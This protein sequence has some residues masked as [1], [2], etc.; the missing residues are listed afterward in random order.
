MRSF[1]RSLDRRGGRCL[2]I[3][4][5]ACVLYGAALFTEDVDLWLRP[6]ARDLRALLESLASAGAR[7]HKLTPP[8]TLSMLKRG[9]GFHFLI[10][11]DTYLDV[12]GRPPRVGTFASA[13]SRARRIETD[14]GRLRVVCP[15]DLVLLK[16]TNR[17]A[18]YETISNLVRLR[19]EEE[20]GD[21]ALLRWALGNT[22]DVEDLA[23]FARQAPGQLTRGLRRKAVASLLPLPRGDKAIPSARLERAARHLALESAEVQARGRRYWLPLLRELKK[24][25]S[26]GRL[27]TPG[28]PV[29]SLT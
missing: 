5:Q 29:A 17:I 9:H 8:L 23:A 24:L 20:P 4:G 10:P 3:S 16:R 26:V 12:M 14:W 11:P 6:T 7:V 18:D 22:F 2:L 1:L 28:T 19:V 21:P 13:W 27:I 15:E 25:R